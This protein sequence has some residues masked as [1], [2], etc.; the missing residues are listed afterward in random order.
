MDVVF[1][2]V[3]YPGREREFRVFHLVIPI[4]TDHSQGAIVGMFSVI[5]YVYSNNTFRNCKI[6]IGWVHEFVGPT[7]RWKRPK[8]HE[9]LDH[10]KLYLDW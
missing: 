9:S 1:L 6:T 8:H 5:E 3:C 4:I 2:Q 7:V 10:S